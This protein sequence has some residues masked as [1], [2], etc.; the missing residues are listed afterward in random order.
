MEN[1]PL[2]QTRW[3]LRALRPPWNPLDVQNANAP[4]RSLEQLF[5]LGFM[6]RHNL[7][8]HLPWLLRNV[9]RSPP[10]GPQL[11]AAPDELDQSSSSLRHPPQHSG[12]PVEP[13][14]TRQGTNSNSSSDSSST[15]TSAPTSTSTSVS[16]S[17]PLPFPPQPTAAN[18]DQPI[19]RRRGADTVAVMERAMAALSSNSVSHRPTLV[20]KQQPLTTPASTTGTTPI[21]SLQRAY[22]A[23]LIRKPPSS[24]VQSSKRPASPPSG[25]D[26]WKAPSPA[27]TGQTADIDDLFSDAVDLTEA[28]NNDGSSSVLGFGE[29]QRLWREDFAERPEPVPGQGRKPRR[30][31]GSRRKEEVAADGGGNGGG[32]GDEFPDIDELIQPSSVLR[33]AARQL[34]VSPRPDSASMASDLTRAT[35]AARTPAPAV[36]ES[37][38]SSSSRKRKTSSSPSPDNRSAQDGLSVETIIRYKRTRPDV[39]Y[40]S[41]EEFTASPTRRSTPG[42]VSSPDPGGTH[43]AAN[44]GQDIDVDMSSPPAEAP[45][46][47]DAPHSVDP[48]ISSPVQD[49]ASLSGGSTEETPSDEAQPSQESQRNGNSQGSVNSELERNKHVLELLLKRPSVLESQLRLVE[50]QLNSNREEWTKCLRVNAPKEER[51]RVR[52]ARAPLMRKQK[53]LKSAIAEYDAFKELSNKREALVAALT[54]AFDGGLDTTEDEARLDQLS[55]EVQDKE[56]ELI[57]HLVAAGVD[58]LDFLK[59][60]NDSIAAP[61]SPNTPVVFATQ[62]SHR[63]LSNEKKVIPEYNSQVILQTQLS[64]TQ[65]RKKPEGTP[66]NRPVAPR[67]LSFS[68]AHSSAT[69]DK[70]R[71]D[72]VAN[73]PLAEMPD[74]SLFVTDDEEDLMALGSS[75][76]L[77]Q[78]KP[79][80]LKLSAPRQRTPAKARGA[81]VHDYFEGFS[82]DEEMLAAADSFEQRR[83]ALASD[84]DRHRARSVLS[85]SSGNAGLPP[86]TRPLA[87]NAPSTQP[88]AS[89][90]AD[91]MRHPWSA[92]V[93]RALKDRFRMTEFRHNQLEA[94][95]ATL[96]GKDAFVLMP[97][98]GGKSLCYQL[99]AVVNSGKTRGITIVISPLLSLMTDQVA[100]LEELNILAKS[101][102]SNLPMNLRSHILGMFNEANPEHFLQLLYVTPEMVIKSPAFRDGLKTLHRKKKLARI[103]IDEAHCVSHWGHDFRPDYQQI[104]ELRRTFPG[105]P[106]MA[107]TAT[108][109]R[110]VIADVKHNLHMD[111]C[112]VFSQSFDRPNLYYQVI[113][114]EATFVAGMADL[115]NTK[116]PGQSGIIYTLSRKSAEGTAESLATKHGIKARYYHAQVDSETRAEVQRLWQRGEVQVVVATIAFGM[117]IDKPDVRFVIHQHMPKNLEGYYQETGR[118]GRD[119]EPSG[120]YLYFSYADLP[121]L[122]RMINQ[123]REYAKVPEQKERLHAL[124]NQMVSYCEKRTCRRVQLLQYFGE[125]IDA[126]QC[127]NNCDNCQNGETDEAIE[128]Q[129]FT[130]CAV[131]ILLAVRS[132][133]PVTLGR[134]VE[135]VTGRNRSKHESVGGFGH[136]KGMKTYEVQRVAMA[137]HGEGALGDEQMV[138]RGKVPI[139]HF[140]IGPLATAYLDGRRRLG[141]EVPRVGRSLGRARINARAGPLDDEPSDFQ[142]VTSRRPPPST[143]ISSPVLAVSKKRKAKSA[144]S[145]FVDEEDEE[146]GYGSSRDLRGNGYKRDHFVVSDN[147][148]EQEEEEEEEEEEAFEPVPHRRLASTRQRQQTLNEL[149]PPISRDTRLEEAG[150]DDIHLDIVQVFVDKAGE[151]EENLRNRHGLRRALFTEQQYREMVIRWTTSV[152]KMYTIRGVD[153]SKVD[154]YGAKFAAL[155]QKFHSQYQ[156]MMGKAHHS[157]AMVASKNRRQEV[158]DLISDDE[159]YDMK[160]SGGLEDD[161]EDDE[162][163]DEEGVQSSR[164]FASN[165]GRAASLTRS[166]AGHVQQWHKQFEE[167]SKPH[168]GKSSSSQNA[169]SV[170]SN[171]ASNSNWRGGKKSYYPKNRGARG[172]GS[173]FPRAGSAG[174]V[175][176]RKSSVSR[177][178]GS[179]STSTGSARSKAS[180]SKTGS[181]RP[182]GSGISLMPH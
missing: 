124:L 53:A 13:S 162:E 31:V 29:D 10:S 102:N 133:A 45:P 42:D 117:G 40:D 61:D 37:D 34:S 80:A 168:I 126:S 38:F 177:Q 22:S 91:L 63:S 128:M 98:G 174:G 79:A 110:N 160:D 155:V 90:R 173:S 141:L 82:D 11:P 112:E 73:R 129:D 88:K 72:N 165:A 17:N 44:Q 23:S 135:I 68:Q 69:Q 54:D 59:D 119:G 122:R 108:A 47:L 121:S 41:D 114:R 67:P 24:A 77:S 85:E 30:E 156:E 170:S 154:L 3:F 115:I 9:K 39:V 58:D 7:G 118:A 101:F 96:A 86:R 145:T 164:Y 50:N 167:L 6:T 176:K 57:G 151:I 15:S 94:I 103:V 87:R 97:T 20:T 83:S 2:S 147:E 93:R 5:R 70:V 74:E 12:T 106:V 123:D 131:A 60:P 19:T 18:E 100:H 137:L 111:G 4:G 16:H 157:A 8:D 14:Q 172:G 149:G 1:S 169:P 56:A 143:N 76:A 84:H 27:I 153:K 152:A 92:D 136:C 132:T 95:N 35:I 166:E 158:V 150:I 113:L 32:D 62:P 66:A 46:Q 144:L 75:N 55:E 180:A 178:F 181:K 99:P 148:A 109:T 104:G 51:E 52:N 36:L 127:R 146:T 171:R 120:C 25:R 179:G 139:T 175:S 89:I 182:S 65:S 105:V 140:T 81:P 21:G 28:D 130:D 161:D 142:S 116:Y 26:T 64:Q 43:S 134:V 71:S 49:R 78:P 33:P 125:K 107:L 163:N 138:S 48:A 159:D